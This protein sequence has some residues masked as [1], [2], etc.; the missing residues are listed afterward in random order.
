MWPMRR[1]APVLVTLALIGLGPAPAAAGPREG[2]ALGAAW[3][4]FESGDF[5]KALGLGRAIDRKKAIN[6]DYVTYLVAQSAMLAGEPAAAL[7]EFRKLAALRGSRFRAVADWR[8]ADCLWETGDLEKAVADYRKL[9][10]GG[11]RVGD[12]A[13][14]RFRI[15]EAAARAGRKD[16]AIE[17]F[18]A[19]RTGFPRHPLEAQAAR[20]I[21]ELGGDDGLTSAQ[22]LARARVL[23]PA[24]KWEDSLAELDYIGDD[25]PAATRRDRDFQIGMTLFKM[26]RQYGRAAEL[27]LAIYPAMGERAAEALF[28]GARALS[29]ADRDA[30]AIRWYGKVVADYPR[31]K[32]AA[33]AQFLSGWLE[34][35]LGRYREGLP[36]LAETRRRFGKGKFGD[37]ALWYLGLSSYLLGDH[38]AALP[39]FDE[40]ARAGDR[41]EGGKGQYWKARTLIALGRDAEARPI[42]RALVHRYP[43]SWYALLARTRLL[44]AGEKIAPFGAST[45]AIAP[46]DDKP[47]AAI[48]R[49][50]LIAEGDELIAAGLGAHAGYEMRR[51]EKDFLGRHKR[52]R[53]AALA[54]LMD[55]YRRAGD[56]NRPW[57]LAVV[58]GGGALETPPVGK[59]RGWWQHAYPRAF[60][61]LIDKHRGLGKAPELYLYSIMRKESG[62]DPH[63]HSY[64]DAMGLL[65]MIPATT[66]RVAAELGIPYTEDLLFDPELNIRTG[67]WYI[68]HLLAKFKGQ[69]PLG[70]G[71]FNSGPRPVMK[72]LDQWGDRPIDELVELVPYQQTREYMKKVTE[73][74]ARYELLYHGKE[75]Q[76]P[77]TVDKAYV[78]DQL[79]Y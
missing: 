24:K 41:L 50:P 16:A 68:G 32:W 23:T 51:G 61:P 54:T 22:R 71:S 28:H 38:A 39:L 44:A 47:D 40:L 58:H 36:A 75:Y 12:Q 79:T 45:R 73:S 25:Q 3:R 1:V 14:A 5:D 49:D 78:K 64:A 30:E 15:A 17:A 74:Y 26:R 48:A 72:W 34:F 21:R 37:D 42:L 43:L 76:Q 59:A 35:N 33:E 31:S 55:A 67:S 18:A 11:G 2:K 69:I 63:V 46:L 13:L 70:A 77:L 57:E 60:K 65:Q 52:K 29:R 7:V 62:F 4:A 9:V 19:L 66:K 6:A 53:P 20:R 10:A 27:L 56:F 8:V